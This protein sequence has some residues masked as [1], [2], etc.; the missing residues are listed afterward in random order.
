MALAG[1][2]RLEGRCSELEVPIRNATAGG[3]RH[4]KSVGEGLTMNMLMVGAIILMPIVSAGLALLLIA[5]LRK[6]EKRGRDRIQNR[7][8]ALDLASGAKTPEDESS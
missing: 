8:D 5:Q 3:G 2:L 7:P 4:R 6:R 1:P